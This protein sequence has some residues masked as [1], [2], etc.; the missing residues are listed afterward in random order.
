MI[1]PVGRSASFCHH[2]HGEP[3]QIHVVVGARPTFMKA[4]PLVKAL[5]D[6]I[7]RWPKETLRPVCRIEAAINVVCNVVDICSTHK[8]F[9]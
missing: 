5:R 9:A 7:P 1:Y 8:P 2:L 4:T 6:S 3:I